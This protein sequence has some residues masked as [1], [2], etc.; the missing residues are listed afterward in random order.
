MS[1]L[2]WCK[3]VCE[4]EFGLKNETRREGKKE[5]RREKPAEVFSTHCFLTKAW[6]ILHV[7]A[8]N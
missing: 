5:T 8:E 4:S 1:A 3:L 6:T 7:S 2:R